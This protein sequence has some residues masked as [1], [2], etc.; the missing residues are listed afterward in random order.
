MTNL[1]G[2]KIL[3]IIVF[4]P[5][6]LLF[7]SCNEVKTQTAESGLRIAKEVLADGFEIPWAIEVINEDDYLFTERM[8]AL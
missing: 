2:T 6:V 8:S 1:A 4:I 3:R 7:F 5:I